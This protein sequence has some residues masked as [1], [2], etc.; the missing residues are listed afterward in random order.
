MIKWNT[1]LY[2]KKLWY[3]EV[4]LNSLILSR[5]IYFFSNPKILD[6]LFNGSSYAPAVIQLSV[7][8]SDVKFYFRGPCAAAFATQLL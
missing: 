2:F 4:L 7:E 1:N 3:V 8:S 5:I 6:I